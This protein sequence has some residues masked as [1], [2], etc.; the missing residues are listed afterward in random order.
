MKL[1]ILAIS[2]FFCF[3]LALASQVPAVYFQIP[4][5]SYG[6]GS[7]FPLKILLD[8]AT[9][10]NA[11]TLEM[12]YDPTAMQL[13]SIDDSNSVINFWH[14]ESRVN[15]SGQIKIEGGISKSWSGRAGEVITLNFKTAK[16]GSFRIWFN[17]VNIYLADGKGTQVPSLGAYTTLLITSSTPAVYLAGAANNPLV[18]EAQ[19]ARDPFSK[20]NLLIFDAKSRG[21]GI[22][23][24]SVRTRQW[25][26][27]D[28][29]RPAVNPSELTAGTWAIELKAVD[30]AGNTTSETIYIWGEIMEKVGYLLGGLVLAAV[31]IYAGKLLFSKKLL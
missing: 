21:L 14:N 29:W 31:L 16:E 19:V 6:I 12:N 2:I 18:I 5:E 30:N 13:I 11:L 20:V 1:L 4:S 25:I 8:S 15:Q 26:A 17:Q 3:G 9:P 7:E 10:I 24:V 22:K 27:W 28:D 23:S